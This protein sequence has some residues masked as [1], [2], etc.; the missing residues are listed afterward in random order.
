MIRKWIKGILAEVIIENRCAINLHI[1]ESE[2]VENKVVLKN[3]NMG[4]TQINISKKCRN[5]E[6]D[7]KDCNFIFSEKEDGL[8]I[9]QDMP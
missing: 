6:V 3:S 7:V 9:N 8:K 1:E 4:S 5:D 2:G